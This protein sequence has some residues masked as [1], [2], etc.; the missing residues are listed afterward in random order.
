MYTRITRRSC[1]KSFH[2]EC[3]SLSSS[4]DPRYPHSF[5]TRR[6]S[7]LLQIHDDNATS[8]ISCEWMVHEGNRICLRREPHVTDPA[9]GL[10]ERIT[11]R[12]LQVALAI[13]DSCH[14]ELGAIGRPV[15]T[16]NVV[17]QFARRTATK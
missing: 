9:D 13:L 3:H 17:Q 11:Y 15:S 14:R 1:R 4:R 6:S 5:P 8:V 16:D 12:V 10:V 2:R 7:D